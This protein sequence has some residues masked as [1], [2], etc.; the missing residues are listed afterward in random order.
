MIK[1]LVTYVNLDGEEVAEEYHFHMNKL[2]LAENLEVF[3]GME[4]RLQEIVATKNWPGI[5]AIID[6]LIRMSFGERIGSG[7]AKDEAKTKL[8]L[9]SD[10]H[11][12]LIEDLLADNAA[13]FPTFFAGIVPRNLGN[14]MA[15]S[16]NEH[17]KEQGLGYS[18]GPFEV[19]DNTT[20]GNGKE[21]RVIENVTTVEAVI[22]PREAVVV[23]QPEERALGS[24][25]L[26]ELLQM[27]YPEFSAITIKHKRNWTKE[28]TVAAQYR[29]N[30]G[31]TEV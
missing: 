18:V 9:Q 19:V 11:S 31:T 29:R 22:D 23:Q 21:A 28:L 20:T 16:F 6:D 12:Q 15:T 17:A 30:E 1:N 5:I 3:Q 4:A 10:A 27:P 2:E 13:M 7:F 25:T 24:Y 26:L 8:F 14:Q